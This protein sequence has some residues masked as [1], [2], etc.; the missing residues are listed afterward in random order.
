M[1]P[2]KWTFG[3]KGQNNG[4]LCGKLIRGGLRKT[5]GCLIWVVAIGRCA[6]VCV[7][8]KIYWP[9]HLGLGHIVNVSY[10]SIKKN[11]KMRKWG[12][13]WITLVYEEVQIVLLVTFV[14]CP[15]HTC[16]QWMQ[17]WTER[18]HGTLQVYWITHE[19]EGCLATSSD[20]SLKGIVSSHVFKPLQNYS[21]KNND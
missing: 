7:F 14:Q 9:E 3:V 5:P 12:K 2:S 8:V 6:H 4:Y 18:L 19:S 13:I 10:T 17:S 16:V 15:A 11:W 1:K 21:V 20:L